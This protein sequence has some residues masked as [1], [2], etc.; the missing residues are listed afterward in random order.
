[1][2]PRTR[3]I[4]ARTSS[5]ATVLKH[6]QMVLR[7]TDHTN[8]EKN[9]EKENSPGLTEAHIRGTSMTITSKVM[10]FTIGVTREYT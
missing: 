6:G 1:M 9:M 2:E 5:M 3:A 7:M 10:V 4:G 8:T